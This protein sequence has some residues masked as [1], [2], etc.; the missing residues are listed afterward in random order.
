MA[1]ASGCYV[2]AG[3]YYEGPSGYYVANAPPPPQET[4][5]M[6]ARPGYIWVDGYWH[7]GGSRW[8]WY[9]GYYARERVGYYY[10]KGG[11]TYREGRHYWAP[12]RWHRR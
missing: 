8:N 4:V 6:A 1:T 11:W 12:G 10:V 5:V 7:W 3:A 2:G 9:R